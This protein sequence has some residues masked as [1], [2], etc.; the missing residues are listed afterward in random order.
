M[1][2]HA[3]SGAGYNE[4]DDLFLASFVLGGPDAGGSQEIGNGIDDDF[5]RSLPDLG[6]AGASGMDLFPPAA[7]TSSSGTYFHS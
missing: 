3:P 7:A 6:Q 2:F 1:D 5:L 4:G